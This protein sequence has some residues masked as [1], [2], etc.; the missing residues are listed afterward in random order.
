MLSVLP[1]L[2]FLRTDSLSSAPKPSPWLAFCKAFL[3]PLFTT[4]P[5]WLSGPRCCPRSSMVLEKRFD[6]YIRIYLQVQSAY[7]IWVPLD[8]KDLR[9]G[10]WY[11]V[12]AGSLRAVGPSQSPY[13][14]AE[15]FP[16]GTAGT[17]SP[18]GCQPSMRKEVRFFLLSSNLLSI[19]QNVYCYSGSLGPLPRPPIRHPWL[20][21]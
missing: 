19:K 6:T 7:P 9:W 2:T 17:V 16:A 14:I 15:Y 20:H 3:F 11:S 12:I 10:L 4:L 13:P 21:A 18:E 5:S 1:R 8:Q